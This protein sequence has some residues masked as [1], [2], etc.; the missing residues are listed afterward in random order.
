[1]GVEL[2]V[3]LLKAH[4][5]ARYKIVVPPVPYSAKMTILVVDQH[6][7]LCELYKE[8][9]KDTNQTFLFANSTGTALKITEEEHLN[10]ILST[11]N[12]ESIDGVELANQ[13]SE[14]KPH[15]PIVFL[16]LGLKK[17]ESFELVKD[18]PNVKGLLLKPGTTSELEK[19][20]TTGLN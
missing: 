17:V 5:K 20:I 15:L 4:Q 9:S 10:L 1:M 3:L 14:T 13:L 18:L 6:E 2:K 11:T 12:C 8:L 19:I 16:T 7:S